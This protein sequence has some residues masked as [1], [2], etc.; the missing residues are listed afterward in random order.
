MAIEKL[1]DRGVRAAKSG[2][3]PTKLDGRGSPKPIPRIYNDGKGLLLRV[4]PGGSKSWVY[5]YRVGRE[6][7]DVG[8]GPYP[9]R[10]LADARALAVA[11]RRLRLDGG[12][13][14]AVRQSAKTATS[15]AWPP[16]QLAGHTF[17]QI[18]E[19]WTERFEAGWSAQHRKDVRSKFA[20]HV[21]PLIGDWP[22]GEVDAE[23]VL[24]VLDPTGKWLTKTETMARVRSQIENC[25][26]FA[27]A[28]G[29]RAKGDN[30]ARWEGHLEFSLAKKVDIADPEKQPALR[31]QDLPTYMSALHA[32]KNL[33]ARALEFTI[34]TAARTE[35][36]LGATWAE[37]DLEKRQW[38]LPKGRMK[39]K[40]DHVVPLSDSA[41]VLLRQLPGEQRPHDLVFVGKNGHMANNS[42][43][44]I[45]E[46][47]IFRSEDGRRPTVHGFRGTFK[48]WAKEHDYRDDV[49]EM[50][51]AHKSGD[52]LAQRYT[53]TDLLRHRRQ[54]AED[55]AEYCEHGEPANAKIVAIRA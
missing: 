21:Y 52:D 35:E 18:A 15:A 9:E 36:V 41:A 25:L 13:P 6:V 47:C 5:R 22:V 44:R 2:F 7:F 53:H 40:R 29:Y 33:V 19:M 11:Q 51:L 14:R 26:A 12:D 1:T 49:V 34:L 20:V 3:S 45:V 10:S 43:T 4:G 17:K 30:P 16:Q 31:W 23:A 50:A 42:M 32:N 8:L 48:T 37:I 39:A 28:E 55:W 46:K 24:R 27:M 38:T 54:V